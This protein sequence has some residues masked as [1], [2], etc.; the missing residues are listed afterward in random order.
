VRGTG[1]EVFTCVSRA[2]NLAHPARLRA[3]QRGLAAPCAAAAAGEQILTAH[4]SDASRGAFESTVQVDWWSHARMLH[5]CDPRGGRAAAAP[6]APCWWLYGVTTTRG[7]RLVFV[8]RRPRWCR[9][10]VPDAVRA[11][12]SSGGR[13]SLGHIGAGSCTHVFVTRLPFNRVFQGADSWGSH[14][15]RNGCIDWHAGTTVHVRRAEVGASSISG[16][17]P[18]LL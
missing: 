2:Q 17:G 18:A 1:Y 13:R 15:Q 4:G 11:G 12:G 3:R 9:A 5:G 6:P 16:A 7:L 8:F 10:R 14:E